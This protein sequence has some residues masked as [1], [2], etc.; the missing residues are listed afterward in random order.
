MLKIGLNSSYF[1]HQVPSF[2]SNKKLLFFLKN[3]LIVLRFV[4]FKIKIKSFLKKYKKLKAAYFFGGHCDKQIP[5]I[6]YELKNLRLINLDY[7]NWIE[8]FSKLFRKLEK[9]NFLT[10][11]FNSFLYFKIHNFLSGNQY[12][13]YLMKHRRLLTIKQKKFKKEKL[14]FLRISY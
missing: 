8:G 9:V 2:V 14:L 12:K 10:K 1:P 7:F 13:Y 4:I 5:F 6:I 11:N 3:I